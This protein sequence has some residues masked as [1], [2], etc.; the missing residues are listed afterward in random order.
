MTEPI[1]TPRLRLCADLC[2]KGER[3]IDVGCD[4]GYLAITLVRS[5][6]VKTALACD[7]RRGPLKNAGENIALYGLEGKIHTHLADGLDGVSGGKGDVVTICGMGGDNIARIL[8]RAPWTRESVIIAQPMTKQHRLRDFLA[9]NGYAVSAER[10]VYE[11]R[12][13]YTAMVIEKGRYEGP[14]SMMY[15][16]AMESDPLFGDWLKMLYRKYRKIYLGGG[17][18]EDRA[19][20]AELEE[21]IKCL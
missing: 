20:M 11:D 21:K 13:L 7:L 14:D 19:V 4:H 3:L 17:R 5:G 16:R 9:K 8:E 6:K 2:P 1:L 10:L 18:P 15:S 12:R